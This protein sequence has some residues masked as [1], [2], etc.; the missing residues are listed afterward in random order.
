MSKNSGLMKYVFRKDLPVYSRVL[1]LPM[2]FWLKQC[3]SPDNIIAERRISASTVLISE[4]LFLKRKKT[5]LSLVIGFSCFYF[6]LCHPLRYMQA[7][8]MYGMYFALNHIHLIKKF[9]YAEFSK[10]AVSFYF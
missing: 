9:V 6:I 7:S 8:F 1:Y 5:L 10:C 2:R 4:N 3:G